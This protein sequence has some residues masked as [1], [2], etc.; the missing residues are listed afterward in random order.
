MTKTVIVV[1]PERDAR[2]AA[3]LLLSERIG[4]LPVM[5]GD[6]LVGIVTETDFLTAFVGS[7]EPAARV[8]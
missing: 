3:V 7:A 8:Q 4:A 5:D 1:E 6:Q 2:D